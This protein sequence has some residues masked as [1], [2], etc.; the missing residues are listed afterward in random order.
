[1]G[2][3]FW[4]PAALWRAARVQAFELVPRSDRMG[5]MTAKGGLMDLSLKLNV[6]A[7]FAVFAFVGAVLLPGLA[8][9][10]LVLAPFLDSSREVSLRR[11]RPAAVAGFALLVIVV[12]LT[13]LSLL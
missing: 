1:M 6:L 11:R 13:V 3:F 7:V 10:L 9:G 4:V 2:T 8:F 12:T 5:T